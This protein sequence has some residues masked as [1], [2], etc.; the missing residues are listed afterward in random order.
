M[1]LNPS[2]PVRFYGGMRVRP[3][4]TKTEAVVFAVMANP[5]V[6]RINGKNAQDPKVLVVHNCYM[7]N[8]FMKNNILHGSIFAAEAFQFNRTFTRLCGK[9][10]Y[11]H[12]VYAAVYDT[13]RSG[14][15]R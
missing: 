13:E 14:Y 7:L 6:L 9:D 5:E 4:R 12:S 11:R 15:Y 3:P 2:Q 8:T 10:E 1:P